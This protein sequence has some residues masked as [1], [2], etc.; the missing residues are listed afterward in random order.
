M[1]RPRTLRSRIILYFC[2]Y[3]AVLLFVYSAAMIGIFRS[4]EDLTYNRQLSEIANGIAH[5]VE[6]HGKIPDY[7]P[8]HITVYQGFQ[9]VPRS[10]QKFVTNRDTGVFE[11]NEDDLD[12]HAAL[13]PL[14]ST[15]QVL[16]V[17][18]DVGSF[19]A[20]ERLESLVILALVGV[21]LGVLFIGWI[22]ARSLSNRI[23]TPISDLAGAVRSLSLQKD[24]TQ[25]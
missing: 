23:L 20:S 11:I 19:E 24:N 3:L 12:H 7:L 6:T 21:G 2:A 10:L 22:L 9:N 25:A 5:H 14:S 8:R 16:Y 15:G 13:I 17:F 18:Y 1:N 4:A